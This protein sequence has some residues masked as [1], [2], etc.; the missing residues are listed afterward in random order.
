M[1]YLF[2]VFAEEAVRAEDEKERRHH[3]QHIC[4]RVNA[5]INNS[6]QHIQVMLKRML[7]LSQTI[8]LQTLTVNHITCE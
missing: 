6:R 2:Y 7:C 8:S 1:S 3:I 4:K 5:D